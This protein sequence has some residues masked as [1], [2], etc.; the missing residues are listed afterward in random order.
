MESKRANILIIEDHDATRLL[1]GTSFK[2]DYHV[3]VK[4]DGL[5]GI[6]WLAS[7]NIP[8]LIILDMQ[9]PRL[10][11]IDFLRQ[12]N[13]SGIFKDIPVLI[14]S[15]NEVEEEIVRCFELGV[16]AFIQKPFNPIAL[17][18]KVKSIIQRTTTVQMVNG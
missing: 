3:V 9:M 5:D 6:A 8:N 11:G 15:G 7:G 10:S 16:W 18:D 13:S 1:L 14:V 12:I 4:K 2:N 17:K